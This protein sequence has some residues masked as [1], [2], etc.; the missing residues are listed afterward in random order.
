MLRGPANSV[1]GMLSR[2]TAL[3]AVILLGAGMPASSATVGEGG[4]AVDVELVIA[5]DVST[6]MDREEKALQLGGFIAAFRD[7]EVQRAI[8][9][10]VNG[11]IAVTYLEWGGEA[12]HK[13]VVPW[14]LIDGAEAA[15]AFADRLA[16]T[17]PG[18]MTF[19]TA[20]GDA[21][22]FGAGLFGAGGFRGARRVIDIS[23]DGVSN[24]GQPLAL[25]RR[26]I[27]A[28]GITINGL[29]IIYRQPSAEEDIAG[30][31]GAA[32]SSDWLPEE[33]IAYFEDEVIGGPEAF[34]VPVT[35]MA[36]YGEAIRHKLIREI[37]GIGPDG[38]DY[39]AL[40]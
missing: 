14:M 23:G 4:V 9:R 26:S 6:S 39:S 11:R 10:G 5:S 29:P 2:A 16:A 36:L 35:S 33:L 28:R 8:A 31:D 34:L 1:S 21:L 15:R 20:M 17:S 32:P 22:T 13:V 18:R 37:A 3:A 7:P 25:A 40:R 30:L 38:V 27:L 24:R 12:R 19:G